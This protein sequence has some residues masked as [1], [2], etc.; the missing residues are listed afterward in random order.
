MSSQENRNQLIEIALAEIG[1][2][3]GL[4]ND[5]KYAA[6]AGHANNFPWCA[7]FVNAMFKKAGFPKALLN[8]ASCQAIEKWA[9]E[10]D[11]IIPLEQAKRGDVLLMDFSKSGVSQHIGIAIKSY[12]PEK[13]SIHTIEGN[14]GDKS[15]INGDGVYLKTRDAKYIRCV[16]KPRY[17]QDTETGVTNGTI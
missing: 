2:T 7:T 4:K 9:R 10:K 8:S 3:E 17:P 1:F 5:N 6:I 15:Q 16:I 13:K 12:N 11:L 14:T